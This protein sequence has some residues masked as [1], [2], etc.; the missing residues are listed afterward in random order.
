M[1][2]YKLVLAF[3]DLNDLIDFYKSEIGKSE[4]VAVRIVTIFGTNGQITNNPDN[5]ISVTWFFRTFSKFNK[6]SDSYIHHIMLP[7]NFVSQARKTY[8]EILKN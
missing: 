1:N 4:R 6:F 5:S 3:N 8:T 7:D 2:T